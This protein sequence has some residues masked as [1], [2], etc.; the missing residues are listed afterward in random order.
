MTECACGDCPE[1]AEAEGPRTPALCDFC[2]IHG[3]TGAITCDRL[4]LESELSLEELE[5]V[6]LSTA[7][8]G[9]CYFCGAEEVLVCRRI[10][11]SKLGPNYGCVKDCRMGESL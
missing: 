3:C 5:T 10:R 6:E 2:E 7:V 9:A 4:E 11:G 8:I 1:M